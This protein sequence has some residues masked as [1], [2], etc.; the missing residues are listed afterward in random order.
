MTGNYL[1]FYLHYLDSDC[2]LRLDIMTSLPSLGHPAFFS[3]LL[4]QKSFTESS[5]VYRFCTTLHILGHIAVFVFEY[6][7]VIIRPVSTDDKIVLTNASIKLTIIMPPDTRTNIL[8]I[9]CFVFSGLSALCS[10]LKTKNIFRFQN[11]FLGD[12]NDWVIE[13]LLHN[14]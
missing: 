12:N 8:W 10:L 11:T 5:E 2:Y 14:L 4:I 1:I 6:Y 7:P 9:D 3:S 13:V